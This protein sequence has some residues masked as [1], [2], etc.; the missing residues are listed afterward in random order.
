MPIL[1]SNTT[2]KYTNI[3]FNSIIV[4]MEKSCSDDHA[5]TK[6]LHVCR[7]TSSNLSI[8]YPKYKEENIL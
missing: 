5:Q 1:E 6:G 4:L 3:Y 2:T 8:I 7:T